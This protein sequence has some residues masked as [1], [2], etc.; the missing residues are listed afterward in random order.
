MHPL[1]SQDLAKLILED[2]LQDAEKRRRARLAPPRATRAR[3]ARTA[4]GA[5]ATGL[6]LPSPRH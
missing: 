4:L 2:R 1:I 5:R 6:R 3:A